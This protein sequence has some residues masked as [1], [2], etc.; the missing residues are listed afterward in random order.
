MIDFG[1]PF[2]SAWERTGI[3]LFRSFSIGKWF[4]LGFS[5]WL[6]SFLDGAGGSNF[7]Y[8]SSRATSKSEFADTLHTLTSWGLNTWIF[9]AVGVGLI[10]ALFGLLFVWLGARGQFMFLDNL[11][12]NR[13][14]ITTPWREFRAAGNRLFRLYAVVCLGLLAVMTGFFIFAL[15]FCWGDLAAVRMRPLAE[16]APLFIGLFLLL[17]LWVPV[18]IALF[19]YR[20]FGVPVMYASGGTAVEAARR[21]GVLATERPADFLIYLLIRIVMGFAF[22]L[23][24]VLLGCLTCC[25]GFLP[26]VSSVLTLPLRVFRFCYTLDCLAQFGPEFDLWSKAQLPPPQP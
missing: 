18:L 13:A 20:E 26:Y 1:K 6:A 14:E 8:R 19:F 25:L 21:I 15:V 12:R 17:I 10:V 24:A 2:T 22:L 5:A 9:L 11:V 7:S 16:Y 4:G 23:S 3:V